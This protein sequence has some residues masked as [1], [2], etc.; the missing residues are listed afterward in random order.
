[1]P[2]APDGHLVIAGI[3]YAEVPELP[4]VG[5]AVAANHLAADLI[6]ISFE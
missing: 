1:M 2:L 3:G 6:N 4:V 5:V